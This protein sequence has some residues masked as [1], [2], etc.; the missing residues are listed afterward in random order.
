MV[1][2]EA[3]WRPIFFFGIGEGFVKAPN[4]HQARLDWGPC[5]C[6]HRCEFWFCDD[7]EILEDTL[8]HWK[9]LW[10]DRFGDMLW[11]DRLEGASGFLWRRRIVRPI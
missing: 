4:L 10:F 2:L 8:S 5:D 9:V 11:F 7:V 1:W 3:T 6:E